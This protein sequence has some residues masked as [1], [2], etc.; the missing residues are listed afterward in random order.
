[1]RGSGAESAPARLGHR[2]A[3][4]GIRAVAVTAVVLQ[5][6]RVP[7]LANL[8]VLL[9][10]TLS[11]FLIT[12]LLLEEAAGGGRI[13]LL[14]FWGRRALRLFPA[15]AVFLGVVTAYC[16]IDRRFP[17]SPPTLDAIPWALGYAAN[18]R[19]V[20]GHSLGLL[21]HLWSLAVEEQF[22][23][24]WP[25]I[26]ALVAAKGRERSR[27]VTVIVVSLAGMVAVAVQRGVLM[28]G[29]VNPLRIAGAD[30]IADQLLLGCALAGAWRLMTEHPGW[31]RPA[32]GWG[33]LVVAAAGHLWL[34]GA[35][36]KRAFPAG[37][38]T[39]I[40][41][42]VLALANGALILHVLLCER[43]PIAWSLS[44]RPLVAIGRRSYGLYLW[45]LP[46][47]AFVSYYVTPDGIGRAAV[48]IPATLAIACLS[49][50]FVELPFLRRKDR[51]RSAPE[52]AEAMG[53]L[54]EPPP[55]DVPAWL[56]WAGNAES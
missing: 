21:D 37:L 19:L 33:A 6:L 14:R 41:Y 50:Q 12:T 16:L 15:L 23:L 9:F 2:G 3:L 31:R 49:Y 18:W 40:A 26:V 36:V 30:V 43:S 56:A 45:Q 32:V 47:I 17:F 48:A 1:M 53:R 22:Y 46:V 44:R 7:W 29:P 20:Q 42:V 5:H 13:S 34:A 24:V 28:P 39:T 35:P 38:S 8:G 51:L 11:G 27:E 55:L 54:A 4:D 52:P 10:F 25:L